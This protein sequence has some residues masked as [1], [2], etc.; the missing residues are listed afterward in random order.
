MGMI[1]KKG[2]ITKV[3]YVIIEQ[4]HGHNVLGSHP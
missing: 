3:L 4:V 1:Q 2:G